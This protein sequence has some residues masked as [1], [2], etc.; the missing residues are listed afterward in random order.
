MDSGQTVTAFFA[1]RSTKCPDRYLNNV[2][3]GLIHHIIHQRQFATLDSLVRFCRD[4]RNLS[5]FLPDP[6]DRPL[7]A[8]R[9]VEGLA[10]FGRCGAA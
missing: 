6:R 3:F 1:G 8:R 2:D 5:G 4:P 9:L 7:F 10:E